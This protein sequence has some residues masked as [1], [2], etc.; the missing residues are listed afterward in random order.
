[1]ARGWS[2]K[3]LSRTKTPQILTFSVITIV[4]ITGVGV[5]TYINQQRISHANNYS[6]MV[7]SL[8]PAPFNNQTPSEQYTQ[9]PLA[10]VVPSPE[11]PA[12]NQQPPVNAAPSV[13]HPAQSTN[14][15]NGQAG[16]P[17]E[18]SNS[19]SK[20]ANSVLCIFGYCL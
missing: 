10:D 3:K 18:K 5:S 14:T 8:K 17:S 4:L 2:H 20:S 12:H 6:G 1:M 7:T 9:K 16:K 13:T 11:P 15:G 19:K